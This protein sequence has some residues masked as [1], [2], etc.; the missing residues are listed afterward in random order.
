MALAQR[1][2]KV[3][4]QC[5][6]LDHDNILLAPAASEFV[7]THTFRNEEFNYDT[8]GFN[9]FTHP[10][11]GSWTGEVKLT[12][13]SHEDQWLAARAGGTR[14]VPTAGVAF[15]EM[16]QQTVAAGTIVLTYT[17]VDASCVQIFEEATK[18][19]LTQGAV[20]AAPNVYSIAGNV[21]TMPPA[22]VGNYRINY[23]RTC[24]TAA[25]TDFSPYTMQGDFKL[26]AAQA[27]A[28]AADGIK[29]F[30]SVYARS[31]VSTGEVKMSGGDQTMAFNINNVVPNDLV[32]Y[33]LDISEL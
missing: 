14:T 4:G 17:P 6:L 2:L 29:R 9:N 13:S 24:A 1:L 23:F 18:Q 26:Y 12:D 21:L 19:D 11:R 3:S 5:Y 7:L 28:W 20:A 25:K 31:C 30:V 33:R 16:E 15:V 27:V 10:R 22:A 8:Y 32:F